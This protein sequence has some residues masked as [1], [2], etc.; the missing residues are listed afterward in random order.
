V[1]EDVKRRRKYHSPLRA[2]QARQ[3]RG[4]ILET[5]F[6]L[7]A[8]GGYAATTVASVAEAAAVSPE[9]IYLSFGDKRGLLAAV[10][11]SAIAPEAD[12][13][14]QEDAWRREIVQLPT[15]SERLGRMVEYS[16]EILA[17]TAPIHAVIR[18]A[19]DKE[20]F[21]AALGRRLLNERLLNQT[22]R[23]RECLGDGLRDGLSVAEAGQRYCA[24]TSPE[25]YHLLTVEFG[26]TAN[27][28]RRWL[29]D[30]LET[31]LLGSVR[32]KER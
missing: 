15:A 3:T 7:F 13:A 19:A 9:T 29:T 22:D 30:L 17:R 28:H 27:R 31:E 20:T 12:V 4:K 32:Q 25:L 1:A 6:R 23:L 8:E 5:A 10:I 26:W 18:G 2:D 11:E 21:A 24:L 14:S 16:C